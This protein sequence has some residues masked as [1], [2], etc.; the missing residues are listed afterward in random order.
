MAEDGFTLR[1]LADI[2]VDVWQKECDTVGLLEASRFGSRAIYT[3]V[4]YVERL[5]KESK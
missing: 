2:Y 3:F 1:Q 4:E 5:Q